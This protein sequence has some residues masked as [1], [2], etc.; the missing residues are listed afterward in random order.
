MNILQK[1]LMIVFI[2][3][4]FAQNVHGQVQL[5]PSGIDR[6]YETYK[7][8]INKFTNIFVIDIIV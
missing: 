8:P 5:S 6:N 4:F 2:S 3:Y 7:P 1:T